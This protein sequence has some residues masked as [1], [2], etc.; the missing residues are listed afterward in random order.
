MSV[1][2]PRSSVNL[3]SPPWQFVLEVLLAASALTCALRCALNASRTNCIAL[4]R[5]AAGLKTE[6]EFEQNLLLYNYLGYYFILIRKK[7]QC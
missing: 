3:T 4:V 5:I 2:T 7:E 6:F 1:C